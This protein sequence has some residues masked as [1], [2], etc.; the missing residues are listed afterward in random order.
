[1]ELNERETLV[2]VE[3]QLKNSIE[4]QAQITDDMREIF[5]RI[6][7]ESKV[8]AGIKGDLQTHLETTIVQRDNCNTRIEAI[9]ARVKDLEWRIEESR[10]EAEESRKEVRSALKREEDAREEI[11]RDYAIFKESLKVSIR[12]FKLI[13]GAIVSI[14]TIATPYI[15]LVLKNIL[16]K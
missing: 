7:S 10:K 2:K 14:A 9:N 16:D 8:L 6:E 3:Q 15:T 11:E 12:N 4:N 1:M 13:V 5:N